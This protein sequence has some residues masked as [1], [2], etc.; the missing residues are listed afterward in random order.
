[1]DNVFMQSR[2][3][4]SDK[5]ATEAKDVQNDS[6]YGY[7][8]YQYLPVDCDKSGHV[9]R[10]PNFAYDHVNLTGRTGYGVAEG[11]VVDSYS[12]LRN[13]PAQLTRDRCRIQLFSRIF[14]GGPN[15]RCGIVDPDQEMPILQGSGSRDLAGVQYP[16]ARSLM[17][18]ETNHPMPMLECIKSVQT[19]EH[20]VES[21]VRGGE[22]TRDIVRRAE[23]LKTCGNQMF[24]RGN[25]ANGPAQMGHMENLH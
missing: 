5:C 8:M 25:Y 3:L 22:P 20:T 12:Q 24:N 19:P 10:F 11:C 9:A 17:E 14:Q 6:I 2:R 23:F 15:L 21:W 4:C 13:D 7:E 16:C 1:M 18:L